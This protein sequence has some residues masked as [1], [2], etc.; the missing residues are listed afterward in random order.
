[1][2]SLTLG[3]NAAEG[4]GIK[5]EQIKVFLDFVSK[6]TRI[7]IS[8]HEHPDADAYGSACGLA[9]A[10]R[11]MGKEIC[12]VNGTPLIERSRFIPAAE[13]VVEK[14]PEN[15]EF[16]SFIICDCGALSRVGDKILE[17]I[18]ANPHKPI[19]NIDHHISN[20]S[21]GS[22][23]IVIPE[24]SSTAEVIC[25][26]LAENNVSMT[27]DTAT[28][29]YAGISADSGSF[30]YSC[31][32]PYTFEAASLCVAAGASPWGIAQELYSNNSLVQIKLHA[33]AMQEMTLHHS[34]KLALISTTDAMIKSCDALLSDSEGL[35]EKGRDI[36]GVEV[37]ILMKE[38]LLED[39]TSLW[40]VSLR[41]KSNDVDVS[42]VA[43]KFGGGGHKA[44]AAFRSSKPRD[45]I[46]KSLLAEFDL[47]LN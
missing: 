37:S 23:N 11:Q 7:V 45:Q 16:E 34:S 41:S 15:F 39:K 6:S 31:V 35:V 8:T 2:T 30:K 12:L 10:L 13:D 32:R 36:A 44:A 20:D 26:L 42:A 29:L 9:L 47:I 1:M 25:A 4:H 24:A 18:A 3:D 43:Q 14:I 19:L 17:Q 46:E 28:C 22:A 33:K 40:R 21:F 27:K 38:D 5:P